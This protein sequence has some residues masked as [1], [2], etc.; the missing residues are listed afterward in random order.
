MREVGDRRAEGAALGSMGILHKKLGR[1]DSA[2]VYYRQALPIMREVGFRSGEA[3]TLI[4]MAAVHDD[5]GWPDSALVYYGQALAISQEVGDRRG[6]G[7]TLGNLG[8]VH[9]DLGRP[10][11]ALVYYGQALAISREV[12]DRRSEA[13]TLHNMGVVHYVL[14]H[15]DS[16]LVLLRKALALERET[17]LPWDEGHSLRNLGGLFREDSTLRDLK[18][19]VAYYDSAAVLRASLAAHAGS[20]PNRLSY[21]EQHVELFE[22]WAMAWLARSDDVGAARSARSALAVAERGRAQALLDLM[23]TSAGTAEKMV[24]PVQALT[25]AGADLAEEG[26]RLAEAVTRSGAAGL[27]YMIAEDTVLFWLIEPSGVVS[28]ARQAVPRDS[29][30]RLVRA[31]RAGLGVDDAEAGTQLALRGAVQLEAAAPTEGAAPLGRGLRYAETAA[32]ALAGL[33]LPVELAER[34]PEAGEL[35]IVPQGPLA[36]VPF[37]ALPLGGLEG[38]W[39]EPFGNRFAIRYAPSLATLGLAEGQPGVGEGRERAEALSQAVVVGNP[40]MPEVVATTGERSG[41]APLPRAAQEAGWLAER[42]GVAPLTGAEA[43]EGVVRRALAGSRLVHLATHGYAYS[44][45]ARARQSFVAL[46]PDEQHDGL[47]TVGEILDDP[48]LDLQAELVVLS[49]C[50]TGLGDLK[51]AEGTVGLQRAFLAKGARSVLVSLWSVS[52]VV[53]EEL[54]KRFY[55]HWLEDE[56]GPSKAEALRRA[57]R[58]VRQTPGWEHPRFWAGFQLVGAT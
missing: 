30:A 35:V 3:Y 45:E 48:A 40:R 38:V 58:D 26:T 23:W 11:S 6:E 1:P 55:T 42:L 28:V 14:G 9:K 15:P 34:L 56:D 12:G 17:S 2:L 49:A 25:T 13:R 41:L 36:L 21:A 16:A 43:T 57:Q 31:L 8:N 24:S 5:L 46:A 20:D 52:D 37:S 27:S 53:T 54:M 18:K 39:V 33:L 32:A 47:L 22:N 19:A 44:T 50:Q 4:N 10:D 51:E 29:V 7:I